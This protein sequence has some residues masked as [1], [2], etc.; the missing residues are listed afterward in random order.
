MG[1]DLAETRSWDF[2]SNRT[3][4][5]DIMHHPESYPPQKLFRA[6]EFMLTPI[7]MIVNCYNSDRCK[8]RKQEKGSD[9]NQQMLAD[10]LKAISQ[11]FSKYHIPYLK[12]H[13]GPDEFHRIRVEQ[14]QPDKHKGLDEQWVF[15]HPQPLETIIPPEM[16][17]SMLGLPAYPQ[18]RIALMHGY[19]GNIELHDGLNIPCQFGFSGTT[20]PI[21]QMVF[22]FCDQAGQRD[23]LNRREQI[24]KYGM[25]LAG[26]NFHKQGYH[27]VFEVLPALEWTSHRLLGRPYVPRTPVQLVTDVTNILKSCT[28]KEEVHQVLDIILESSVLHYKEYCK[29]VEKLNLESGAE[30]FQPDADDLEHPSSPGK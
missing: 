18:L 4:W 16:C 2:V 13:T 7:G 19:D 8:L 11:E 12:G 24:E 28:E 17:H 29:H 22:G 26:C 5:L 14:Y 20:S 3:A 25:V 10:W 23:R 21:M 6:L 30:A 27:T 1:G 15:G 9:R